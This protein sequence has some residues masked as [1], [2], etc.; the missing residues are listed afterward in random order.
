MKAITSAF[1]DPKRVVHQEAAR[2]RHAWSGVLVLK[3]V[4][5]KR[6]LGVTVLDLGCALHACK[7]KVHV[8]DNDPYCRPVNWNPRSVIMD[9]DYPIF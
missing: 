3:L 4:K 8:Y 2:C 6:K 7:L 5:L 1:D 9:Q